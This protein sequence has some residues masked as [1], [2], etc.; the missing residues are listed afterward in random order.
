VDVEAATERG[1]IVSN[2]PYAAVDDVANHAIALM[3]ACVRRLFPADAGVRRGEY[4]WDVIRPCHN[5]RG[6]TLGLVAF[7]NTAQ[8]VAGKMSSAFGTNVIAYDPYASPETA[9]KHGVRLTT[10]EEVF[11]ESDLISVHVPRTPESMN[12]IHERHFRSMKPT[13]YLVVV[14]RGGVIDEGALVRALREGWFAGAGL[15]VHAHEPVPPDDPLLDAPNLILTPHCAGYSEESDADLRRLALDA[16]CRVLTGRWPRW[17]VNRD[18]V[19]RV[20]LAGGMEE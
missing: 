15:D 9:R 5:P 16:A 7:G 13:A 20:T 11:R 17:I 3:L 6:K 4:E 19:P 2:I 8:A 14:G 12:M 18:V 10:L 1:I